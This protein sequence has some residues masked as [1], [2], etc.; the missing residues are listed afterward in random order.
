MLRFLLLGIALF[1]VIGCTPKNETPLPSAPTSG[2]AFSLP[3]HGLYTGAYV[4]FGE[5]EDN[6]TYEA[7]ES[8]EKMVGK[9]QAIIAFGSFW[10][11]QSFPKRNIEIVSRYGALPLIYWSPWDKPYM[12]DRGPDRFSLKSIV[13]GKWDTY[14]DQ[15]ADGAKAYGKP[16]LVAWGLEM[17]GTWFPWSGCFYGG[18]K[19]VPGKKNLYQG[20][21]LFKTA[22]RRVVDRVRARGASNIQW[23]FHSMNYPYP[24]DF[25]NL[26]KEYYPGSNYVDWL[27]LSVYGKQF[28]SNNAWKDFTHLCKDP[29]LEICQLDPHKPVILAEWGIGEFPEAGSKADFIL[30]ALDLMKKLPRLKAAVFWHERWENDDG[31]FSNLRVN[32]SP[33]SLAA[34]RKGI[35]D[36]A[37]IGRPQWK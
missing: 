36:P 25:W 16:L 8:F 9:P 4:D 27:G 7:I 15:W 3:T 6:V 18:G 22:Y 37:F 12:E 32:S 5:G 24:W 33:E 31:T 21:E 1:L 23:V 14:I 29:Y 17:N 30:E 26:M 34:Y 19:L 13:E 10:G 20:P 2:N 35:A 28:R 11:E